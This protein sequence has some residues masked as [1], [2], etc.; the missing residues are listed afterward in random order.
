MLY[1]YARQHI[2]DF[3]SVHKRAFINVTKC[4]R[5]KRFRG[6]SGNK[7]DFYWVSII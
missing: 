7:M 6:E 1:E 4:H 5:M 2:I 3:E